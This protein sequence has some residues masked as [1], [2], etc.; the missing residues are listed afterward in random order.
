MGHAYTGSSEGFTVNLQPY[1]VP[2]YALGTFLHPLKSVFLHAKK[3]KCVSFFHFSSSSVLR[4][5][6]VCERAQAGGGG[7]GKLSFASDKVIVLIPET[8]VRLGA[9]SFIGTK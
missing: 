8:F 3:P 1:D 4:A 7:D 9:D 2:E 6:G 5:M